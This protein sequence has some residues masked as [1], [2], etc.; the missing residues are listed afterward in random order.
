V[1]ENADSSEIA[2]D[3]GDRDLPTPEEEEFARSLVALGARCGFY[4]YNDSDGTPWM[5]IDCGVGNT[6]RGLGLRVD[7]DSRGV[8]GGRSAS[9]L[10]WDMGVR[11]ERPG[12]LFEPPARF[13]VPTECRSL[14]E[15][16]E[17]TCAQLERCGAEMIAAADEHEGRPPPPRSPASWLRRLQ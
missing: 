9:G 6:V 11:A 7:F 2:W 13:E 14:A 15:L 12:V 16:A 5:L 1:G 3:Y 17:A 10:N 8:R 4:L